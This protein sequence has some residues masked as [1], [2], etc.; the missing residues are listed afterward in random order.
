MIF[1][2]KPE[3]TEREREAASH[4]WVMS[5]MTVMIGLPFP[6][7]NLVSC[8]LF[9]ILLPNKTRFIRFH[10]LQAVTSQSLII[11]IN[12][13]GL[14]WAVSIFFGKNLVTD[15]FVAY[16]I[17]AVIFNI[18]DYIYNILAVLKAKRGELYR[19]TF[20][21]T[22]S[23][24]IYYVD[25]QD[26]KVKSEL[27]RKMTIEFISILLSFGVL[28][29]IMLEMK[30]APASK[31]ISIPVEQEQKLGRK[32]VNLILATS[33]EI[34]EPIVDSAVY[35][36]FE[37]LKS[38]IPDSKYNYHLY[39]VR[40]EEVNALTIPG[41]NIL[42]FSGLL[43]FC[44]TPEELAAVIAHEMGHVENRDVLSRM[45]RNLG[46]N[47]V[48][49]GLLGDHQIIRD[50]NQQLIN[51][52]FDRQQEAAADLF[53]LKLLEKSKVDPKSLG[54]FFEGLKSNTNFVTKNLEIISSHPLD[55]KRIQAAMDYKTAPGFTESPFIAI[56]WNKVQE[57]AR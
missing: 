4:A 16:I 7:L 2:S 38:N 45:V 56:E 10:A 24:W 5:L 49:S 18:T 39:V 3:V 29:G 26:N 1:I 36:V 37:R 57:K 48:I 53:A 6:I 23:Y 32:M 9:Y 11:I 40:N 19:F 13:V 31:S 42:I 12:S 55:E 22:L 8:L 52:A 25:K 28:F 46:I 47:M 43:E 33:E 17:A 27:F 15:E 44:K 41:G 21:G 54:N 34:D 50:L 51:A 30:L 20:F 14:S 35:Q